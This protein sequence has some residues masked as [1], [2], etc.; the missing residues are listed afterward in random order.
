ML[1]DAVRRQSGGRSSP[2][3]PTNRCATP[4]APTHPSPSLP[5]SLSPQPPAPSVSVDPTPASTAPR[6]PL[7]APKLMLVGDS[8]IKHT[9][10]GPGKSINC[11]FPGATI[12]VILDKLPSLIESRPP[13]ISKIIIHVGS[14]DTSARRSEELKGDFLKLVDVLQASGLSFFISGPIPRLRSGD[15]IFSRIAS[16]NTW[17]HRLCR[18]HNLNYIDNFNLFWG[19]I[20]FYSRDGIH[21]CPLG[22][23]LLAA[24][25][26][27]SLRYIPLDPFRMP[28]VQSQRSV[29]SVTE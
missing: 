10:L 21:P 2:R 29:V 24:N 5:S 28:T 12:P 13:S 6:P 20:A 8:I 15:E 16:L 3:H 26:N 25:I 4:A 22:N 19:R 23:K 7:L 18:T 14:N 17:L 9:R 11:C 1:K 27:T